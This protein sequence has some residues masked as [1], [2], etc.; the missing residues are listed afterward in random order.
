[1]SSA[2]LYLCQLC[3][4]L[5]ITPV[6]TVQAVH[7]TLREGSGTGKLAN[8]TFT[9]TPFRHTHLTW[10]NPLQLHRMRFYRG[11]QEDY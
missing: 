1:M 10:T 8:I 4:G 9:C 11:Q 7:G 6:T 3:Q 5:C 2:P